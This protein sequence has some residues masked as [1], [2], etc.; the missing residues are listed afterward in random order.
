MSIYSLDTL[1]NDGALRLA[2]EI[3]V[4]FGAVTF[5]YLLVVEPALRSVA[6]G[7]YAEPGLDYGPAALPE[8]ASEI[9]HLLL[10]VVV[11]GGHLFWRLNYTE[12][13]ATLREAVE[14]DSG[15]DR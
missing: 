13:G 8:T 15:P 7:V 14:E 9:T 3:F 10:A 6:P 5:A 12:L 4:V 1:S 2:L 11:G